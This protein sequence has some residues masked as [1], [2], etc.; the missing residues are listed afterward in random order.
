MEPI[1][2]IVTVLAL[3]A[4]SGLQSVAGKAV[5]DSYEG[6][7][8]IIKR[9]YQNLNIQP[10]PIEENLNSEKGRENL[11]KYWSEVKADQKLEILEQAKILIDH[12]QTL[13]EAELEE[14]GIKLE[15][16]KALKLNITIY[17]NPGNSLL[18]SIWDK[19]DP[20]LQDALALAAVQ[21]QRKGENYIST[22][23]FFATL[24]R[25]NP[26]PLSDFFN[27][28][29]TDALP[30]PISEDIS[31]DDK[32]F[33]KVQSLSPCMT[34][35]LTKLSSNKTFRKK[36]TN[37]EVFVDVAKYGKGSSVRRLRT[38]GVDPKK[39]DSIVKQLG[40]NIAVEA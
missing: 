30:E 13:S 40:W 21:A 26:E 25:L 17:I 18:K 2:T 19:L 1:T 37:E 9:R 15:D 7:K 35:S 34:K 32:V 28:L 36:I 22:K 10:K 31:V 38:Y 33:E 11:I 5:N 14:I 27:E 24:R 8:A 23:I 39:I 16:I 3:G 6:L 20:S 12:I 4:A 29:P